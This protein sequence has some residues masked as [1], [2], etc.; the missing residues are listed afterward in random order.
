M[1][2]IDAIAALD[3]LAEYSA[4]VDSLRAARLIKEDAQF[5]MGDMLIDTE[6]IYAERTIA[7]LASD[8][9]L[10]PQSLYSYRDT[11]A[12]YPAEIRARYRDSLSYSHLKAARKLKDIDQALDFLEACVANAWSVAAAQIEIKR[13]MG[14]HVPEIPVFKG[15]CTFRVMDT[16]VMIDGLEGVKMEQGR[17]Y[18]VVIREETI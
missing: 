7:G 5:L 16:G 12:F 13:V 18:S 4:L 6:T 8:V 9:G 10:S 11:A 2:D 14:K 15:L 17:R 3:N 1:I